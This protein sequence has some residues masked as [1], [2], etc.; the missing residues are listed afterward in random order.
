MNL[1]FFSTNKEWEAVE[2]AEIEAQPTS[3]TNERTFFFF[4]TC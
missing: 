4:L 2:F 1:S 3:Q